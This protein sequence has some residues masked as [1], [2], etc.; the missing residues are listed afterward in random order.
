MAAASDSESC[1]IL[2]IRN[3]AKLRIQLLLCI[4][5]SSRKLQ[6]IGKLHLRDQVQ[7]FLLRRII[8]CLDILHAVKKRLQ[9]FLTFCILQKVT[10]R[11]LR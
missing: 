3:P 1:F 10:D 9:D 4:C 6:K 2:N 11:T 5:R 7:H 8:G